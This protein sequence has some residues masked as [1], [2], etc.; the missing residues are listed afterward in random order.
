MRRVWIEESPRV[1]LGGEMGGGGRGFIGNLKCEG[2][3][4]S[5]DGG[6][7]G[8]VRNWLGTE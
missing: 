2:G 4:S 5:A 8:G 6:K 3:G 7:V 1:K